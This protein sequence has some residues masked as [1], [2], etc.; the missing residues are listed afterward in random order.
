VHF[1]NTGLTF[2]KASIPHLSGIPR[3]SADA[4]PEVSYPDCLDLGHGPLDFRAPVIV[5]RIR[6]SSFGVMYKWHLLGHNPDSFVLQYRKWSL[7]LFSPYQLS[8]WHSSHYHPGCTE[9]AHVCA[10]RSHVFLNHPPPQYKSSTA[11]RE[12]AV[13]S[14]ARKYRIKQEYMD[15]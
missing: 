9:A 15:W 7:K 14:L 8:S 3:S 11:I 6:F 2:P 10:W 5:F 12:T 1:F 4:F 13:P